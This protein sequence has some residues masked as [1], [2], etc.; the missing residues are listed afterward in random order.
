M[1]NVLF[2]IF[3][4]TWRANNY[5]SHQGE[6]INGRNES[7]KIPN[8]CIVETLLQFCDSLK[9]LLTEA[10]PSTF[11]EPKTSLLKNHFSLTADKLFPPEN[12][13][14]LKQRK[15]ISCFEKTQ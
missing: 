6:S 15:R 13:D 9:L 12:G 10:R 14:T 2:H 7:T 8:I 1:I 3:P 4:L 11:V 5:V